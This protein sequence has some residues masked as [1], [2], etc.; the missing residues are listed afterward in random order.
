[1]IA[2]ELDAG[3][4]PEDVPEAELQ[5]YYQ[6]HPELFTQKEAVRVSQVVL[7]TPRPPAGSP[8]RRGRWHPGTRRGSASWSSS[9]RSTRIRSNAAAT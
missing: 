6:A 3:F 5:P 2:K 9:T 1:M 8:P 7:R 4:K